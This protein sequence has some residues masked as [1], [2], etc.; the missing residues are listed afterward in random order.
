M[1]IVYFR[2]IRLRNLLDEKRTAR[3]TPTSFCFQLSRESLLASATKKSLSKNFSF[4]R[5]GLKEDNLLLI[6]LHLRWTGPI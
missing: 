6:P 2:D 1:N 5:S 3:S 4:L